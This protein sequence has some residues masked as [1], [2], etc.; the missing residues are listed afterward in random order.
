M[1][2]VIRSAVAG[3]SD[4]AD[5][6]DRYFEASIRTYE[7]RRWR[8]GCL[9]GVMA[10]ELGG[11]K[12]VIAGA[13]RRSFVEW[14]GALERL[15]TLADPTR[16]SNLSPRDFAEQFQAIVQGSFLVE[17]ATG[18]TGTVIRALGEYRRHVR[19]ALRS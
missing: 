14:R 5:A 12:G 17:R 1:R 13:C 4:P 3:A 19:S 6:I 11:G 2:E 18:E 15:V 8:D 7:D 9:L 16:K 10:A